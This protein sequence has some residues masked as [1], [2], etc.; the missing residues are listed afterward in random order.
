MSL[1]DLGGATTAV[2]EAAESSHC[3]IKRKAWGGRD[4]GVHRDSEEDAVCPCL[5]LQVAGLEELLRSDQA[6]LE[7][8]CVFPEPSLLFFSL[9]SVFSLVL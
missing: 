8:V 5:C 3:N 6:M 2:E 7:P 1:V 4:R 9:V